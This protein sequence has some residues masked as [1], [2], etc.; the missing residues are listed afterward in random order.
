MTDER[1]SHDDLASLFGELADLDGEAREARLG[2]I[3]R[4]EPTLGAELRSLLRADSGPAA[5]DRPIGGLI[6]D[7]GTGPVVPDHVGAF[8]VGEL[9][10]RGGMGS[11][12]RATQREPRREV[13]LKL[14]RANLLAPDAAR[15]LRFEAAVLARLSHPN[16]ARIYDAGSLRDEGGEISYFAMELVD[17]RPI[18]EAARGL[19][20]GGRVGLMALVCDAVHHAHQRGVIHRD[21]KPGNILVDMEGRPRVLD[22]G[23]ARLLDADVQVTSA[24]YGSG[25]LIGT[26][27]YMSPEQLDGR[28]DLID[29]RSDVYALGAVL[30]ELLT[31][32]APVAVAGRSLAETVHAAR[33]A[34]IP[35]PRR[36][37]PRVPRDLETVVMKSLDRSVERRYGSASEFAADLRRVLTHQ[38]VHARRHT[39]LYRVGR[40]ARRNP[41]VCTAGALACLLLIAA[42]AGIVYGYTESARRAAV[43]ESANREIAEEAEKAVAANQFLR[44]M[45]ISADPLGETGSGRADMTVVE[46]LD[47][48]S[49]QIEEA[50]AGIPASEASVRSTIGGVYLSLGMLEKAEPHLR[51][52]LEL[53]EEVWGVGSA[54]AERATRDLAVLLARTDRI[55]ESIGMFRRVLEAQEQDGR[56]E[57]IE[58]AITATRLSVILNDQRE[59]AQAEPLLREAIPILEG[60]GSD[61]ADAVPVALNNLARALSGQGKRERAEELYGRAKEAFARV[62][63][64]DH[65]SVAVAEGNIAAMRYARGD[66]SGAVE[67]YRSVIGILVPLMGDEHPRV[68]VNRHNLAFALYDL[69]DFDGALRELELALHA[70][71]ITYGAD[72]PESLTTLMAIADTLLELGRIQE[73]AARYRVAGDGLLERDADDDRGHRSRFCEGLALR[74]MGR[75]DEADALMTPACEAYVRL[76]GASSPGG[77]RFIRELTGLRLDQGRRED[78]R[79]LA[80]RLDPSGEANRAVLQRLD[81]GG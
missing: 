54:D 35:P 56:G 58:H 77:Q 60:E 22:F 2:E 3:E 65:P 36:R 16:I 81:E 29:T 78:A 45:L 53:H 72:H 55:D 46:M 27:A 19:A 66:L 49:G 38:P 68:A 70:Y 47:R 10:G 61:R 75:D 73:A 11:V 50:F 34:E 9:I 5:V 26:I 51:R 6:P 13:A 37:E 30:Y 76:R 14:V 17:G 28:D 12:Y 48:E 20:I 23:I 57:S 59:F 69:G 8:E 71:R 79:A 43:L 15:R 18:T 74:A 42:L 63:G 40:F 25:S 24:G 67:S 39:S 7:E 21:L 64:A 80:A 41:G 31:G 33:T 62:H 4:R 32:S 52:S 44:R 1:P